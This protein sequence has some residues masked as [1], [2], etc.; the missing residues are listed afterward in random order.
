[1]GRELERRPN[2]LGIEFAEKYERLGCNIVRSIE[3]L[4]GTTTANLP[5]GGGAFAA[6]EL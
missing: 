4:A 5:A 6:S 1:M 3:T 2:R